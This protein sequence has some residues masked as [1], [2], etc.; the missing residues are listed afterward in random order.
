MNDPAS[1]LAIWHVTMPFPDY[2]PL[3]T[4]SSEVGEDMVIFGRGTQ[5]GGDV[6]VS[7]VLKGWF[8]G[9]G[10][11]VQRWGQNTV[12]GIDNAGAG[13]GELLIASFDATGGPEEATLS[14][15]DSGGADFIDDGGGWKLAG[16]NY[17]VSGPYN[18]TNSGPGFNASIFDERGLYLQDSM[19][20]WQQVPPAL[21]DPVTGILASTRISTASNLAFIQSVAG[22][23]EP[24]GLLPLGAALL[25]LGRRRQR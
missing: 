24:T 18:D 11:G 5:R 9:A 7:S 16:I 8:W 10:D 25:L 3:Y 4:G 2:A 17:G 13:L 6:L 15:G 12:A 1:D 21:P 22:V 14:V 19:S 23:P 20:V